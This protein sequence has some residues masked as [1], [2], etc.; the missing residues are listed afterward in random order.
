MVGLDH[1]TFRLR[2]GDLTPNTA[3]KDQKRKPRTIPFD[4]IWIET[5][6]L[7]SSNIHFVAAK[8]LIKINICNICNTIPFDFIWIETVLL[9]SS[10]IHFVAAKK[11][12]KINIYN[13][14]ESEESTFG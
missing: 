8:K 2:G 6:L 4:F 11:L 14:S 5:V 13:S 9:D 7:D 3:L 12:I 10:D 1:P